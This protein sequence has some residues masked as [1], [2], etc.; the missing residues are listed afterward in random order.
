MA[1][2]TS[3]MVEF[4][5]NGDMAPG[6]LVRPEGDGPFLGVVVIQEWWGLN[7]QIKG[8]ANRLAEEGFAALTPDLYRG[9]V[10]QE[11][12]EARKLVMEFNQEQAVKDIQGAVNYL[13]AQ[14][15]VV[16]KKAGVMG[17]C[18]GGGLAAMMSYK[19]HDVGAVAVFYGGRDWTDEVVAS[20]SAPFLGL[21]G[22]ADQSIPLSTIE[23]LRHKL[24]AHHKPHE[25]VVYPGAPHAFFNE[26]RPSY[27]PEAA[28]DAWKRTLDWLRRYLT[29]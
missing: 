27:R 19:G 1:Q 21:Y 29:A 3:T 17:F 22:E 7:D 26:E 11:P 12:D 10:A 14:P 28:E 8:V 16:P 6:Y 24:Q 13:V 20:I 18:M 15:F 2:T 4:K 23:D 5:A 25:I 9:K